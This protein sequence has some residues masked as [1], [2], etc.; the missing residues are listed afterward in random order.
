MLGDSAVVSSPRYLT[1]MREHARLGRVVE[2]YHRLMKAEADAAAARA[3]LAD[4]DM[5]EMA[6]EEVAQNETAAKATLEEIMGLLV[7]SDEA[8]SL[9]II[10]KGHYIQRFAY[11]SSYFEAT[12]F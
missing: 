2:P 10:L 7:Q 4:P 5:A 12:N 6:K 8:G 11:P 1:L 9:H 3:L